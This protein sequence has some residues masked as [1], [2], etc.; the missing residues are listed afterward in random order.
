MRLRRRFSRTP[1]PPT[2]FAA[3]LVE[4]LADAVAACDAEGNMVL[5]NRRARAGGEGFEARELPGDVPKERWASHYRLHPRG[6]SELMPTDE[7]PLVRAL[8]GETVRD[9]R[10]D[11]HG[12]GDAKAVLNVS[13]GPVLDA[14]GRIVGAVVVMQD[15]T[16]RA[17]MEER[18]EL[19]S[20]ITANLGAGVC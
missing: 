5:V 9:A 13:G 6:G 15:I 4:H 10:L 14:D 7:L 2:D 17:A 18:L 3:V 19:E 20:A 1:A 11:A 12:E 16:E 8:R